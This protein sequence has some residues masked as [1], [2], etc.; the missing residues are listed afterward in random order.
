VQAP[1][2]AYNA[3]FATGLEK[4]CYIKEII[5]RTLT[6]VFV[7]LL[8]TVWLV[9]GFA[10][11]PA[12]DDEL[13]AAVAEAIATLKEKDDGIQKFF[14]GA[15]AYAVFPSVGKGGIGIGGAH[16]K[17]ILIEGDKT[18]GDTSLSQVSIGFQF[19]GQVYSEY[20]FFKDATA[21]DDFKRGNFELGAQASAVAV[22]AG[23]SADADYNSGV[24]IFTIAKGGLMYEAS[25]GGQKFK[26][27]AR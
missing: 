2:F 19:G 9:P 21:V 17:G 26:Y 27:E 8:A 15:A 18:V 12:A 7:T 3:R 13:E 6:F 10:W 14:D 25:V 22:T 5:V 24:A 16:G 23:A 20:V 4:A 11:T 1:I